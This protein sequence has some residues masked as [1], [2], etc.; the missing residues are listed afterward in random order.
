MY[1]RTMPGRI[2]VFFLC[3]WGIFIVSLIVV[4]LTNVI[5]LSNTEMKGLKVF[6]R[7]KAM[8][9]LEAAAAFVICGFMRFRFHITKDTDFSRRQ[10]ARGL[11]TMKSAISRFVEAKKALKKNSENSYNSDDIILSV[12]TLYEDLKDLK[13]G[14]NNLIALNAKLSLALDSYTISSHL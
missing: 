9:Q 5:A 6:N 13:A 11:R 2:L 14:Q 7:L 3:V 1:P 12:D 4:A 10:A 8:D